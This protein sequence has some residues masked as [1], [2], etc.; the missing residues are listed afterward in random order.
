MVL[1]SPEK[2]QSSR[3]SLSLHEKYKLIVQLFEIGSLFVDGP[4]LLVVTQFD[5]KSKRNF[6]LKFKI[7]KILLLL[8]MEHNI[9]SGGIPKFSGAGCNI[10]IQVRARGYLRQNNRDLAISGC[11]NFEMIPTS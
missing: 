4:N 6:N 7:K 11:N 9:F 2:S 1:L 8:N 10:R 3:R 5:L